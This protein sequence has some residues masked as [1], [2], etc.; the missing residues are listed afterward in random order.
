MFVDIAEGTVIGLVVVKF[1]F[2]AFLYKT[3]NLIAIGKEHYDIFSISPK[4]TSQ[5][6]DKKSYL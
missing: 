4:R 3:I 5:V 2:L 6:R 1:N